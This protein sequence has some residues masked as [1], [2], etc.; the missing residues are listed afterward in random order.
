MVLLERRCSE[1]S[2]DG[3]QRERQILNV[4][5]KKVDIICGVGTPWHF[6]ANT[7]YTRAHT[8]AHTHMHIQR[9][10]ESERGREAVYL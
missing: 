8:H 10:R 7:Q 9:E 3:V 4:C 1:I 6:S 5:P 2:A